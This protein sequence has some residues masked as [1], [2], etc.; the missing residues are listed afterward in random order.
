MTRSDTLRRAVSLTLAVLCLLV[1]PQ[2][3]FARFTDSSAPVMTVG[4]AKLVKPS[5]VTG[6]YTCRIGF[7][8]EGV[9][10][11]V[12]GFADPGQPAGVSFVSTLYRGN[13]QRAVATETTKRVS[14]STG[15]QLID[16]G[17]TTYRLTIVT[18]LGGW[19]AEEYSKTISCGTWLPA[20]GAL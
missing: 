17:A 15:L 6:T 10:V 3:A 4:A 1:V 9:D 16:A 5:A 20:S 13:T 11:N 14:L 19:T 8:T 18:K 7:F 12:T 2:L